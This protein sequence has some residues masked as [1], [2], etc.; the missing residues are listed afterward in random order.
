MSSEKSK[1]AK[2]SSKKKKEPAKQKPKEAAPNKKGAATKP[3]AQKPK[4]RS[5][6]LT[7]ATE[8]LQKL[9][10]TNDSTLVPLDENTRTEPQ[11]HL[12]VGSVVLDHVIG[13]VPNSLGVAPCPGVP[14][15][16]ITEIYGPEGSG[17]TTVALNVVRE[18]LRRD[19]GASAV[20]LDFEH[21]LSKD[22][23]EQ[24]GLPI[25]D[26]NRFQLRQPET[27]ERGLQIMMVAAG[28]GVDVI[29]LDSVGAVVPVE[30]YEK[31]IEEQAKNV[32]GQIGLIA[33]KWSAFVPRF[34]G[35]LA[36]TG[37]ALI[38]I[39]QMRKNLS[40]Y[41]SGEQ[42]Q[43]GEVWKFYSSVRLKLSRK[44]IIQV[45]RY[46][47]LTNKNTKQG[48]GLECRVKVDKSKVSGS[49]GTEAIF[50]LRFGDGIDDARSL[51]EIA[52]SHKIVKKSG[53]W[54]NFIRD[55]GE[56][57]K[58]QGGEMFRTA[59]METP[60]AYDEMV[61]KVVPVL[62]SGRPGQRTPKDE[63]HGVPDDLLIEGALDDIGDDDDDDIKT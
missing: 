56:E 57:V 28:M 18:T 39:A 30:N 7:A 6:A 2:P 27:L 62:R 47:P 55:N 12:P 63:G 9:F 59:L 42:P 11:D 51:L 40:G 48:V 21:A 4:K 43:G 22:F 45:D 26:R 10:G 61:S 50:Y 41:G 54:F 1:K 60:G 49:V 15:S 46:D 8:S 44:S 36:K 17:K 32:T 31:S 34:Q 24:M 16:R 58:G 23:C 29:V 14:C 5:T 38:A 37:T 19:P 53:S 20:F 13:G 25:H 3:K 52:G 35:V 33:R